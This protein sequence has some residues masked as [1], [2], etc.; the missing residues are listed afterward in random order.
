MRSIYIL[1]SSRMRRGIFKVKV[2]VH[3]YYCHIKPH[4]KDFKSACKSELGNNPNC[5]CHLI[6]LKTHSCQFSR[7]S[8]FKIR[9]LFLSFIYFSVLDLS[10]AAI[11]FYFS[12][13]RGTASEVFVMTCPTNREKTV[14]DR[15]IVTPAKINHISMKTK[16]T[17]YK[18]YSSLRKSTHPSCIWLNRVLFCVSVSGAQVKTNQT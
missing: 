12:P 16:R 17:I 3:Y 2:S 11:A 18:V 9:V 8:I 1:I 7:W 5:D 4:E 10:K 14:C 13:I 15:R 6:F